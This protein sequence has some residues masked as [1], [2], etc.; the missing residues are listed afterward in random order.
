MKRIVVLLLLTVL[1]VGCGEKKLDSA[2]NLRRKLETA[3]GCEFDATISA[4][5]ADKLYLFEV[6]C[7]ADKTGNV[8]FTVLSPKSIEGITGTVSE[9][10]G[11]LTFDNRVLAFEMLADGMISP[12][13][14]PWLMIRSIRGG[15]IHAC[16]K[17]DDGIQVQIDDSFRG[18]SLQIQLWLDKD[19][20]PTG[21][22]F[23]YKNRRILSV[24]VNNFVFV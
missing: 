12:V 13:T 4:D 2:M 1:L 3:D 20:M 19:D 6:R 9:A 14:G 24:K 17:S 7:R 8:S 16:A 21:A 5:Y 15:Y 23:I 10:G 11:K 22:E 18:E